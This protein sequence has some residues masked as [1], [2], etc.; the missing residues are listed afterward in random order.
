MLNKKNNIPSSNLSRK[1]FLSILNTALNL[2]LGLVSV[3][4]VSH[5]FG[6]LGMGSFSY[7]LAFVATFSIVLDLGTATSHV[8]RL[9]EGFDE[10]SCI[11]TYLSI[12]LFLS[13]L[14]TVIVLFAL[15]FIDIRDPN[16]F[17]EDIKIMIYILYHN[18]EGR[19]FFIFPIAGISKNN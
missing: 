19:N 6:P 14:Y 15:Y 18:T 17:S 9:S 16:Y 11:G 13:L 2:V 8:K 5:Y 4:F 10:A 1:S 12:K 3:Y 7:A